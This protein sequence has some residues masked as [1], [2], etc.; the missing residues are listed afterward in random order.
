VE[1]TTL[2]LGGFRNLAGGRIEFHSRLNLVVGDNG[3]GKTNLL[4]A[5]AVVTGRSSFR[6][7]ALEEVLRTGQSQSLLAAR[8][9]RA[10]AAPADRGGD[11]AARLA[12]GAREQF[13]NGERI[14]RLQASRVAPIVLLAGRDLARYTGA[15][16]ERRRAVD[17]A[18][19]AL[20]PES[21]RDLAAY[22]RARSAKT[23]LL[24]AKG[25]FDADE[26]AVYEEAM[27]TAGGRVATARRRAVRI[28]ERL[29]LDS[30]AR[31]RSPFSDLR[32]ELVSDL[33]AEGP[34]ELLADGLRA[35]M[36]E[37]S[38]EERRT[39][40]CLAGPH[41]D[42]ALLTSS[43]APIAARASSGENRTLVLAWTLAETTLVADAVGTVP[44]LAF[45]DFDSEWDPG[46]L[47]AFAEAMPENAQI[48]LTSAR[49]EAVRG[50]PLPAGVLFRMTLGQISR[51][52]IL[53]AGRGASDL[54]ARAGER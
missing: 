38:A 9:R 22:E 43:G 14:S 16:A 44:A 45:D 52:G 28:L 48:F 34:A 51:E 6:T 33:P 37:R 36:A 54:R 50:L 24:G 42:D 47:A 35:R 31:L 30:A 1:I 15:P 26:L 18:A 41:R 3:Q 11:L 8:I 53:G 32:L 25:R 21:G 5:L 49:P 40:H 46:V 29:L 2:T 12:V 13:W 17:R 10:E 4:E 7:T 19:Q 20:D 27:A 39:G 23:R